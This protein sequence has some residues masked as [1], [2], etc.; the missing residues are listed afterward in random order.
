MRPIRPLQEFVRDIR[1][2]VTEEMD[3]DAI[4]THE[5]QSTRHMSVMIQGQFSLQRWRA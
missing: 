3:M 2:W 1:E 5:T 4:A